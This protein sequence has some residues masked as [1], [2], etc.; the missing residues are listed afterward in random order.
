MENDYF[1]FTRLTASTT[2]LLETSGHTR[3]T[4]HSAS[5]GLHWHDWCIS[6]LYACNSRLKYAKYE[7]KNVLAPQPVP[8][9]PTYRP[10]SRADT[11]HGFMR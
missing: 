11:V 8:P 9:V 6:L 4:A 1:G 7:D 2:K 5:V 3:G 10:T